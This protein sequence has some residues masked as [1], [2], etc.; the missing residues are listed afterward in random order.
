[1]VILSLSLISP[2]HIYYP[3]PTYI[4]FSMLV[5]FV[6]LC[7]D[8]FILTRVICITIGLEAYTRAWWLV[9]SLA[10]TQQETMVSWLS[11]TISHTIYKEILNFVKV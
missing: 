3:L 2:S 11:E 4:S 7:F 5:I 8:Q 6:V 9:G 10:G 1:M